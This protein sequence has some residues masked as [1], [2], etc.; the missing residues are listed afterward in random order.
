MNYKPTIG[1]EIHTEL[2]TKT[3]MF[4]NSA[5]DPLETHPNV[6]I[7]PVCTG[8]P[9]TLPV[10][11]ERAVK[12]T[13]LAGLALNCRIEKN[14]FFERKNYFYPDL[15]KGYQISQYQKPLCENGFL[16]IDL[17]N[18]K[19]QSAKRIHIR[20]IHLEEDTGKLMHSSD[21]EYSLV[22]FNRAGI[23]LMELVTEPDIENGNEVR[24]FA[25][26]LQL[27]FRYLKISDADMEKGQM[28]IE[29]NIS[30]SAK[31]QAP[32]DKLELGTKV[33]I[34]NLNSIRSAADSVDYEIKRQEEV[35]EDGGK[36]I[37]ETR[38]WDENRQKTFSQR[39]K[40][41]SQDYRYFP[42]PD[43][44]PL[45][46]SD[47]FL[48]EAGDMLTELP[49]GRRKR[50]KDQYGLTD[51]QIK[52]FTVSK[53]LGDYYEKVASELD[54]ASKVEHLSVGYK[55][56]AP[57]E[58]KHLPAKLHS[59]SAN[60]MITEFP[61]LFNMS[62]EE[63]DDLS[64]IKIEPE[65]FAELM[66]M[67]FHEKLS[68]TG[69]KTVLKKMAETGLHPERIMNEFNLSQVSDVNELRK[70]VDEIIVE[71]PKPAEDYKKGKKESLQ[72]LLGK[73]MAKTKGKSNP[74]VI[75]E[76]L[77]EKLL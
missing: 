31:R 64:G 52:I 17:A 6:N 48:R 36:I 61:A 73:I 71:N 55:G 4:C 50:F 2:K 33:E 24:K 40:E 51:E 39:I 1:L 15:P 60:Y 65:A 74:K 32:S 49:S 20:R 63:I 30:L 38:G 5:N 7:C 12:M 10:I 53:N 21:G 34:K 76:I 14:S 46:L 23:P 29:V 45:E 27:I 57:A 16:D 28:R 47:D 19:S 43:L 18:R 72:F 58:E 62:R 54:A 22:D 3:K 67:I 11:N 26:E 69:A 41:E 25:E 42:E 56:E 44:P 13:V 59:L 77:E 8:Q 75:K 70:I 35:L 9:G 66:V 37:Q 68:S